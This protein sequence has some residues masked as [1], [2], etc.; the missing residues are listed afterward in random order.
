[1]NFLELVSRTHKESGIAGSGP[2]TVTNQTGMSAS[3]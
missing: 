1:M 3:S 2:L